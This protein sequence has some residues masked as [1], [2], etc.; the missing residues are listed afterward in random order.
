MKV[1]HRGVRCD[2]H[3]CYVNSSHWSHDTAVCYGVI[4]GGACNAICGVLEYCLPRQSDASFNSD[5]WPQVTDMRGY[6]ISSHWS[7]DTAVCYGVIGGGGGGGGVMQCVESLCTLPR[8]SDA[9]FNND[10]WPQVTI[11]YS[12]IIDA[13]TSPPQHTHTHTHPTTCFLVTYTRCK[14]SR[15]TFFQCDR[16]WLKCVGERVLKLHIV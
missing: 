4:G 12:V 13:T 15:T 9:S 2:R 3:A 6:V 10:D 16:Y 1:K 5:N 14:Y 11:Q 8:Q 7:H